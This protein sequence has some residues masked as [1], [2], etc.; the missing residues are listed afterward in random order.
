MTDLEDSDAAVG[1]HV[2]GRQITKAPTLQRRKEWQTMHHF[3]SRSPILIGSYITLLSASKQLFK[4][5][6]SDKT[7]L[8]FRPSGD[9][10]HLDKSYPVHPFPQIVTHPIFH[11]PLAP[12]AITEKSHKG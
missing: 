2:N 10:A 11:N 9:V 12:S 8:S 5:E 3:G 4:L 1:H 7:A 6:S